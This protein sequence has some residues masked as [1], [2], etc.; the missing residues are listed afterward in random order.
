MF[1]LVRLPFVSNGR[2]IRKYYAI[3]CQ[4]WIAKL[5]ISEILCTV[6]MDLI[7]GAGLQKA[8]F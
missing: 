2:L 1:V 4:N 8:T 3:I 6:L 5:V 7:V